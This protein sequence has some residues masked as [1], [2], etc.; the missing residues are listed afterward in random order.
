MRS[1]DQTI[2][3][4]IVISLLLFFFSRPGI[5]Y[6]HTEKIPSGNNVYQLE[7]ESLKLEKGTFILI[8]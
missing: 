6:E 5:C 2:A 8:R 3:A 7:G 1:P 4:I